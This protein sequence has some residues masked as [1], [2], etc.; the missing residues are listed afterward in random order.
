MWKDRSYVPKPGDIIFFN[1]NSNQKIDHVGN[2]S[3][4]KGNTI[5]RNSGNRC[6]RKSY[7]LGSSWIVGYGV[8]KY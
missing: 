8:P 3:K 5:E 7:D 6:R 2:T 1:W 4:G